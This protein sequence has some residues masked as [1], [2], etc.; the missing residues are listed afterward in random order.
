M[1]K[2]LG[3]C[4]SMAASGKLAGAVVFSNW[5]GRAYVRSLVKPS[6]PKLPKQV[7]VRAMFKFLAQAWASIGDV[8]QATW[9][10]AADAL[11]ISTFNA[12]MAEGQS[13]WRTFRAPSQDTPALETATTATL[14]TLAATLGVRMITVTQ[15]VTVVGNCWAL[16]FFRSPTGVFT[17][18]FDQLVAVL[19]TSGT[20]DVVFVDTPLAPGAYY[21]E[22]REIS[23]DGALSA[24]G[25]EVTATVV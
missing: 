15:P 11:S 8:A 10:T 1:A 2:L 4:M 3:P 16:A 23:D 18:T 13:R 19:P 7:S 22:V 9:E 25:A 21:Y 12:Y 20:N 5:K 24:P 14:G 17:S 6:N